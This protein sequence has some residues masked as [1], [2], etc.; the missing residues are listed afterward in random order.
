MNLN[1]QAEG[2]FRINAE[3]GQEEYVRDQLN[4]GIVPDDIDVHC[5]AGLI[6]VCF[7]TYL[8]IYCRTRS[9]AA[10]QLHWITYQVSLT[11][12]SLFFLPILYFSKLSWLSRVWLN[13]SLSVSLIM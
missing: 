11:S 4:R 3:N 5:L 6:K 12:M 2:I 8:V 10:F 7:F 9:L 13:G 1:V